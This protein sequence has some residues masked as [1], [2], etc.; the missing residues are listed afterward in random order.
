MSDMVTDIVNVE[1][2]VV[3]PSAEAVTQDDKKSKGRRIKKNHT[4]AVIDPSNYDSIEAFLNEFYSQSESQP[5]RTGYDQHWNKKGFIHAGPATRLPNDGAAN[6]IC[7]LIDILSDRIVN[8]QD[9][10]KAHEAEAFYNVCLM[11]MQNRINERKAWLEADILAKAAAINSK[12][13]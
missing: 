1:P 7:L 5:P 10:N 8:T 9:S 2:E 13:S 12:K 4:D 11:F 6:M 3:E